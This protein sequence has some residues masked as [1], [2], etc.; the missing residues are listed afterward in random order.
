MTKLTNSQTFNLWAKQSRPEAHAG[1]QTVYFR[2]PVI[3]S[4]GPHF[5]LACILP[6]CISRDA[7]V[8]VALHNGARYSVTTSKH[9]GQALGAFHANHVP[10]VSIAVPD[11]QPLAEKLRGL[12][13]N[14]ATESNLADRIREA[15]LAHAERLESSDQRKA[16]IEALHRH[17]YL[18]E[19]CH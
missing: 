14:R 19:D 5:P 1:N 9:M 15:I 13:E 10:G 6:G 8:R 4:Y 12:I 16:T 2:G 3:Y 11:F 17:L 7:R 18:S